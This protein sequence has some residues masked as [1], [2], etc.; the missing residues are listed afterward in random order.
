MKLDFQLHEKITVKNR[1]VML[2][3]FHVFSNNI[4]QTVMSLDLLQI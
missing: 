1:L 3:Y 4:G 2:L